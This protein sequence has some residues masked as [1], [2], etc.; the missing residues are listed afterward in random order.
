MVYYYGLN[1]I[2]PQEK[3]TCYPADKMYKIIKISP[4]C[5]SCSIK[6]ILHINASI[7]TI[8]NEYCWYFKSILMP[9][10]LYFT[11]TC[12]STLWYWYFD[13]NKFIFI[14]VSSLYTQLKYLL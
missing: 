11:F 2:D 7:I 13:L 4:T 10:L 8:T 9:L 6:V 5:T 12:I 14:T 3:F 1:L